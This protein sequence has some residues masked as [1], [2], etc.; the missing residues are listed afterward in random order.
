MALPQIRAGVGLSDGATTWVVNAYGLAFG[1]PLLA[2]Q[3][4]CSAPRRS[5]PP[6]RPW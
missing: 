4:T 2:G 6:R 3:R 5:L 1:A